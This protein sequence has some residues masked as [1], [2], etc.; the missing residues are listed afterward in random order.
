MLSN[1]VSSFPAYLY[2][3]PLVLLV[4]LFFSDPQS[5]SSASTNGP[6]YSSWADSNA[7]A[8]PAWCC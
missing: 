1:A 2:V 7:C 4:V 5:R 6:L 8:A 3:V